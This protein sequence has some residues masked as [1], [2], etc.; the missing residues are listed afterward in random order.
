MAASV[1][2]ILSTKTV[3]VAAKDAD[4][5]EKVWTS[6]II[7]RKSRGDIKICW[8]G[9]AD[10]LGPTKSEGARGTGGA[11]EACDVSSVAVAVGGVDTGS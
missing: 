11:K 1:H 6:S 7:A 4:M 2:S 9:G 10:V 5:A 8:S 3:W